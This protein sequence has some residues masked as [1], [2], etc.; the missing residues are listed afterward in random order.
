[1]IL[2]FGMGFIP[3]AMF[4]GWVWV[5]FVQTQDAQPYIKIAI[6]IY[7]LLFLVSPKFSV[8]P[9]NRTRNLIFVGALGG[10]ASMTIGAIGSVVAPFVE[11]L[12]L[13]K[14][15]AIATFGFISVFSN[16]A[17]LPLF[18]LISDKLDWS[19]VIT[20]GGLVLVAFLGTLVGRRVHYGI[21]DA[22][23]DKIFKIMLGVIASKLL[24]WDGL[25]LVL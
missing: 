16:A 19:V 10:V 18:Y 7:M 3:M 17:K 4:G 5:Y 25:R 6:A 9:G 23:F 21:S 15:R 13:K 24:I 8:K 2:P 1:M 14:E 20:I 22:F 11:S 12:G